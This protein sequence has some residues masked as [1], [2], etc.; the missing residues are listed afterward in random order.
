M[1]YDINDNNEP[2]SENVPEAAPDRSTTNISYKYADW[3]TQ[4]LCK[5]LSEGHRHENLRFTYGPIEKPYIHLA[6]FQYILPMTDITEALLPGTNEYLDGKADPSPHVWLQVD[7]ITNTL[8]FTLKPTPVFRDK[9]HSVR[10]LICAFNE[11][12]CHDFI[13]GWVS[14][15]D[16]SMLVWIN[17]W[18]CPGWIFCPR[19]PHPYGNKYHSI[20]DRT[21]GIMYF[22]EMVYKKDRP[23]KLGKKNFIRRVEQLHFFYTW[24]RVYMGW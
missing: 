17:K 11:H 13:P 19:K 18:T 8:L 7:Q 22:V 5:W 12:M 15:G 4:T 21:S 10:E 6:W 20:Y 16:K 1:G 23:Q 14:C 2:A 24:Q 3:N 9:F